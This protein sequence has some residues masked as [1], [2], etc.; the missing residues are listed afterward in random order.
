MKITF[1]DDDKQ[2]QLVYFDFFA[3]NVHFQ[4]QLLHLN[5]VLNDEDSVVLFFVMD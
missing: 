5:I 1:Y 2:L 4:M 3:L